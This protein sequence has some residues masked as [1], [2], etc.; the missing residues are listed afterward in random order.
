MRVTGSL[1]HPRHGHAAVRRPAPESR[2]WRAGPK[3]AASAPRT[4]PKIKPQRASRGIHTR[5]SLPAT[6][7]SHLHGPRMVRG[8]GSAHIARILRR[9]A[10]HA[11]VQVA[12]VPA[13]R[14]QQVACGAARRRSGASARAAARQRGGERAA[15]RARGSARLRRTRI[16][17]R[18][19]A[20]C[21]CGLP[22]HSPLP[23]LQRR[24]LACSRNAMPLHI[25]APPT[26]RVTQARRGGA[27]GHACQPLRADSDRDSA[28]NT[29]AA[30]SSRP[31]AAGCLRCIRRACA[32]GRPNPTAART[33]VRVRVEVAG[34]A[35]QL[36]QRAINA[37]VHKVDDVQ[38]GGRHRGLV[39]QLNAVHPLLR[40]ARGARCRAQAGVQA[41]GLCSTRCLR[42]GLPAALSS[43]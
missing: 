32:I 28:C 33:R 22:M 41:P 40:A 31:H 38:P 14:G 43:Q 19:P 16:A 25:A 10:H 35:Q 30:S 6:E 8:S 23:S 26:Q 29:P 36:L 37:H 27:A 2:R 42:L 17:V 5:L 39:C 15:G 21:A 3:G 1:Q 24:L 34:R 9:L 11:K 7:R 18:R 12:Q 4:T 13:A 20:G